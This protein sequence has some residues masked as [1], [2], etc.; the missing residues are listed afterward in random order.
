[1]TGKITEDPDRSP[2]GTEKLA[3]AT[4]GSNWGILTST[5]AAWLATLTQTLTGKTINA[6]NNTIS[7]LATT[8]FAAG[9]IDTDVTLSNNSDTKL[10]TQKA[11]KAYTDAHAGGGGGTPSDSNPLV[12]G[13]A[14]PGVLT[15]YSRGDHV[16]PSDT[17]RQPLD[18]DLTS[19]AAAS[20]TG[21]MY[22][23]SAVDT[24]AAVTIGGGLSFTA[25]TLA[26]SAAV[27]RNYIAGLTLS[28][29]GSS[30]TFGVAIGVAADST[31]AVLMAL[32]AAYAK[33]TAAWA[34][35]SG[36][37]A[38]DTGTIAAAGW[39]HIFLIRR[40]DTGVTDILISLSPTAP[41][42]PA[43]YTQFRRI[44]TLLVQSSVWTKF[45]QDGDEFRWDTTFADV[46]VTNPGAAAVVRALSVPTG[47]RVLARM[48]VGVITATIGASCCVLLTDL[49]IADSTPS[50]SNLTIQSYYTT[51]GAAI[52][53]A[54]AAAGAAVWTNTSGQIRSRL[55]V[56]DASMSLYIGTQGWMDP[57]G[58]NN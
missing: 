20:A 17:T 58:K 10:A 50:N 42:L 52:T 14:A 7:N 15:T 40:P 1:M 22:Y 39:Y 12:N 25:G 49:S 18:G 6:G 3:A 41:T 29:A 30:I 37:G 19:L 11:V 35:G 8:H 53:L 24:W 38:L 46:T 55:L 56:S 13:V 32:V 9:V 4:T 33:T 5:L 16:H 2:D 26:A 34:L 48:N 28:T 57:R 47:V 36:V 43:N 44:G 23:R 31:N 21:A 27:P 51:G 54:N 45:I